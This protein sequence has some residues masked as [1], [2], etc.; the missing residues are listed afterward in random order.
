[1]LATLYG[2]FSGEKRYASELLR[3]S[4]FF[5]TLCLSFPL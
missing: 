3:Q 5:T 4:P 1:M 2:L